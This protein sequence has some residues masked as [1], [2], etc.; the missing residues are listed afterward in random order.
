[1][2]LAYLIILLILL[3]IVVPL[4]IWTNMLRNSVFDQNAFNTLSNGQIKK[5]GFSLSLTQLAFWT[6]IVISSSIYVWF[7]TGPCGSITIPIMFDSVNLGLLGIAAGT[8]IV[9]QGINSNQ[10]NNPATNGMTA[11][12]NQPARGFFFLDIISD[13]T[14]VSIHRLQNVIWTLIVGIIYIDFVCTSSLLPDSKVIT[15]TLLGLMGVSSGAYLGLKTTENTT[16]PAP[17]INYT[18]VGPYAAGSVITLT[19]TNTGG[20]VI[21]YTIVPTL[22]ATLTFNTTTGIITG[23]V[24]NPAANVPYTIT[25]TNSSGSGSV[26]VTI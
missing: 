7:F 11:Q 26:K 4:G 9:G 24:A 25:A 18:P 13:E 12:Q 20:P 22:P 16:T 19:P 10:Q 14:G 5:P 15:G 23:T 3:A 1:M 17:I 21:A 2:P 8:T 6:V